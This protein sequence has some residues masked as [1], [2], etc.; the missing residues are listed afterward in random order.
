MVVSRCWQKIADNNLVS[1][2]LVSVDV[3]VWFSNS[4]WNCGIDATKDVAGAN[5]NAKLVKQPWN[6]DAKFCGIFRASLGSCVLANQFCAKLAVAR[7]STCCDEPCGGRRR[8]RSRLVR[9]Q[10]GSVPLCSGLWSPNAPITPLQSARQA[11]G[12]SRSRN[13]H[14]C[15][16]NRAQ[17]PMPLPPLLQFGFDRNLQTAIREKPNITIMVLMAIMMTIA[18]ICIVQMYPNYYSSKSLLA[19]LAS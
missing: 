4:K 10:F 5:N 13:T 16:Q 17:P 19:K 7:I 6:N 12:P 2:E 9:V 8:R 14:L 11:G 15:A 1:I 18:N 3:V